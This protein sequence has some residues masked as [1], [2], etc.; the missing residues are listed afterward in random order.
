MSYLDDEKAVKQNLIDA[1][2]CE[3][4]AESL[5]RKIKN[6]EIDGCL[7]QLSMHRCTLLNAMHKEQKCIDCLDYLL[8]RIEKDKGE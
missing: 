4:K 7:K 1:G 5:L 6:G 2:C 8:Y 3:E